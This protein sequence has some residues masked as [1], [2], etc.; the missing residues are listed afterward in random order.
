MNDNH[1]RVGDPVRVQCFGITRTGKVHSS[2]ADHVWSGADNSREAVS[3]QPAGIEFHEDG[4]GAYWY[5]KRD[6]DAGKGRAWTKDND[7]TWVQLFPRTNLENTW[8]NDE[9]LMA[10]EVFERYFGRTVGGGSWPIEYDQA[11]F[12]NFILPLVVGWMS[13]GGT[14]ST[15]ESTEALRYSR[16][17]GIDD[18]PF[19]R[20]V[21]FCYNEIQR[22]KQKI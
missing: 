10:D 22:E 15:I 7:G 2:Y 19:V 9:Y 3:Y 8:T 14:R 6:D 11:Q 4:T 17:I 21:Y 12:F 13:L 16:E 1:L 20:D 18:R 5:W